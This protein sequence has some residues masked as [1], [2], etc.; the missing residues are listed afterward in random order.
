MKDYIAFI[1]AYGHTIHC[2]AHVK[3]VL[4]FFSASKTVAEVTAHHST[5]HMDHC[6]EIMRRAIDCQPDLI[7]A[8][9]DL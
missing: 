7:A 2:L 1:A 6:M 5:W 4:D 8:S 9:R 3:T